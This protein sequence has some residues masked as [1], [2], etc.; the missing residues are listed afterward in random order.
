M[1]K[2]DALFFRDYISEEEQIQEI[3]HRHVFVIIEDILLWLF[4]ALMIPAFLYAFN[5]FNIQSLLSV[6]VIYGYFF[7]IYGLIMYKLFD[8]YADVWIGT[9]SH[10]IAV[11][12]KWFTTNLLFIPYDKIEGIEVRTHSWATSLFQMSDIVIKMNGNTD[13]I[14]ESSENTKKVIGFLQERSS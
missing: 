9:D 14:L 4:F 10:I 2:F 8:W 3:F 7:L 5:V 1:N 6:E 12:W 13:A 11:K